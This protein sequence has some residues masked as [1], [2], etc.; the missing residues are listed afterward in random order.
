MILLLVAMLR[1]ALVCL[2]QDLK[3]KTKKTPTN[4]QRRLP[5]LEND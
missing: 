4:Q 2:P 5:G 3:N 1:F